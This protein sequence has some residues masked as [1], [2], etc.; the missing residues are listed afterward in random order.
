MARVEDRSMQTVC[1]SVVQLL[2][3]FSCSQDSC[4]STFV[5][6]WSAI[7][8]GTTSNW[9]LAAKERRKIKSSTVYF[10]KKSCI[11]CVSDKRKLLH[12]YMYVKLRLEVYKIE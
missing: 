7:V 6:L 12:A 1:E 3:V 5:E 4:V 9:E 8:E 10:E 11:K 2:T